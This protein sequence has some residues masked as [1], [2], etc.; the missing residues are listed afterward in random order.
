MLI[1]ARQ[2]TYPSFQ[3]LKIVSI[4][5]LQWLTVAISISR[6]IATFDLICYIFVSTGMHKIS[7]LQFLLQW[8]LVSMVCSHFLLHFVLQQCTY[9]A[10]NLENQWFSLKK[11][12][13]RT[14]Y[15]W[16]QCKLHTTLA[17]IAKFLLLLAKCLRVVAKVFYIFIELFKLLFIMVLSFKLKN[18]CKW[19]LLWYNN[20]LVLHSSSIKIFPPLT[21]Y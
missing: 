4:Q 5:N 19:G 15:G 2:R 10:K 17:K 13:D 8:S 11:N 9:T 20:I 1:L 12:R 14:T 18:V 6:G 21:I 3:N 16:M 7:T